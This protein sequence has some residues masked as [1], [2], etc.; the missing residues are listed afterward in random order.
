VA[1]RFRLYSDADT[2]G[3]FV[4]AL[5]GRGWDLV[6][7]IDVYPEGQ[8]DRT[9]FE[10]AA[11]EDRV[12]VSNDLD[13]VRIAQEWILA[14]RPFTG[15]VTWRKAQERQA[16]PAEIADAFEALAREI[17]PFRPYPIVYLKPRR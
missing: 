15:L 3:P 8:N 14:G 4:H 2:H 7:A 9:H 13:Q 16:T 12:L 11:K 10:R 1:C 5:M 17:E 6:R